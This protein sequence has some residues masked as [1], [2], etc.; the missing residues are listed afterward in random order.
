MLSLA[1]HR[2]RRELETA[3]ET[4][5]TDNQ[6]YLNGNGAAGVTALVGIEP[7][8]G[9]LGTRLTV[10]STATTYTINV[11][12]KATNGRT[13]SINRTA[14]GVTTRTCTSPTG[15]TPCPTADTQGNQW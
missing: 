1:T 10:A 13:W 15:G 9:Q 8:L 3:L 14:A 2:V 12:S 4:M 6:S 5:Y 11:L 7:A